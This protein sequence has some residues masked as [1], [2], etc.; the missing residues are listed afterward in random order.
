MLTGGTDPFYRELL[1][2]A[3]RHYVRLEVWSGSGMLLDIPS[4]FAGEPEGGLVFGGGG[5]SA[6]LNSRVS[7]NLTVTVPYELYPVQTSDLLAP[8]GNELR[9]FAGVALA[10]GSTP[11]VWQVFRGKIGTVSQSAG[12]CTMTAADRAAEVVDV[13]FVSP[14]NS[15]PANTV[16]EEF[17]RLILDALPNA[18]FGASDNFAGSVGEL[19][20]EFDRGSALDQIAKSVGAVWY[21]LADGSFVLRHYPW[22]V[23]SAPVLTLTDQPGGTVLDWSVSR[24]RSDIY[25]SVTV[26]GERLNGDTPV[27]ATAQDDV[28]GSATSVDGNFGIRSRLERLQTPST[29]GA[30]QSSAEALLRTYVTPTEEWSLQLVPDAAL[31]LGDVVRLL[32]GGRDVIQVVTDIGLPAD[33]NANMTVSTRSLVVGGA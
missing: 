20:W 19:T 18:T 28:P 21:P 23:E 32:V 10:D 16:S 33:L 4:E 24:S 14:Q 9:M 3:H 11:Y 30:A 8:F 7:R 12:G 25:N 27:Y 2:A 22:A 1:A 13:G 29:Q 5:V 6:T 15:Q 31:E 17:E 26:T